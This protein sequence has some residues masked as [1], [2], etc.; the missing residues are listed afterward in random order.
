MPN[1]ND[2][3]LDPSTM[4]AADLLVWL[5][6]REG[7]SWVATIHDVERA[8]IGIREM[9][10]A[11][12]IRLRAIHGDRFTADQID[13]QRWRWL[14]A[15]FTAAKG[16]ASLDV[17]DDLSVYQIPEPGEEVV[18]Q[19]YPDTPVGSYVVKGSTM[20]ATI[21]EARGGTYR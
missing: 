6:S 15:T 10:D 12:W 9:P 7:S 3:A 17:N 13:A 11:D 1:P 5:R 4:T 2:D 19:W 21:D 18:I 20:N 16:G 8:M 14:V